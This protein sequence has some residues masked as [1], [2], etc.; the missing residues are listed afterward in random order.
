MTTSKKHY[1]SLFALLLVLILL[2]S[3]KAQT[4]DTTETDAS[5]LSDSAL[6]SAAT[7][8]A[9]EAAVILP[10]G[11]VLAGPNVDTVCTVTYPASNSQ[12]QAA[13]EAMV[14]Y[15]NAIVPEA[16]LTAVADSEQI[17]TEYR[18]AICAPD[19][20][21]S[22]NYAVALDDKQITLRGSTAAN[23]LDAVNYFKTV[24]FTD[25]YFVIDKALNFT[26][27]AGPEVLSQYPEKYYYYEDIY[28][29]SLAYAF[30]A[31][32]VD[33]AKSRLIVSGEDL[34]DKAVW[35]QGLVT[36][37]DYTVAV[38]DHTVL[39]SLA[40]AGGDVEVYETT[41]SCGDG[42]VMNLYCGEVHAHTSDSDGDQTVKQAYEYA[43]DVAKLDFFAVTDHSNSFSNTIYQNSHLP[44]ADAFNEP[45]TFAALYGYEQ[46]YNIKTGYYGHLNTINR[47]SLTTNSLPLAQFYTQMAKDEDAVVMFNHPG[48]TWGN[49]MEYAYYSPEIDAVLNLTEIK[50]T[51][52]ANYEYALSLTKG[53]HVS[54]VYNEDN[55]DPNWGNAKDACG[56]VL[57]PALTRQNVIDAFNKNRTYTTTD[58]TLKIYYKINDEWMGSRLNNPDNL[59]FSIQLSTENG[60]GLGTVSIIAE[61]GII[62]ATKTVGAKKE[63]TWEF[64]LAPHYDY[65]YIKVESGSNWCYTAPIWIENREQIT[66]G[67]LYQELVINTSGS[68]DHR[69]YADVTNNSGEVMTGVTVDFYLSA[70]SGFNQTKVKPAATVSVGDIAPGAT[71]T[72][73]AD[74]KYSASTP[75][76]YADVKATQNGKNYGAVSYM[77]I[78][79]LYFTEILP[80]TS[81]GGAADSYEYIELYN[82]SDAVIDLARYSMRY[83]SKAGAKAADLEANTWK[84]SG[85]IQP[86]ST[87]VIWMV[88]DT[89]KLTVTDFNKHFGTSLVEGKNIIKLTGAN[90]PHDKPVQLELLYG[91]PIVAR[92][93]YNW[94]TGVDVLANRAITFEYPTDYTMTAKVAKARLDPTP[95]K[96][97][98]GQVPKTVNP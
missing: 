71:V 88:S 67:E 75:R 90:I 82:N 18:I 79:T 48:Y 60:N 31:A 69:I 24:C 6:T 32:K 20:A 27:G 2:V 36:L 23:V 56:Y 91:S 53:W 85:K 62:V 37:T 57:A 30:D 78:S 42:S 65:Y 44:N 38:G 92:C 34:T 11:L 14:A 4:P 76:V 72:V 8:E 68:N 54:P 1:S 87:M 95:G 16:G 81:G 83:Y 51:S 84:L 29:P 96:L 10:D 17:G 55:H 40:N 49:F 35:G 13:A 74:L 59:H 98:E 97:T 3:C 86:H 41:F 22:S 28:T 7:T 21:L 52:A 25:G 80:L 39:L 5:V 61:D 19:S 63:F 12:L 33:T 70:T 43:R 94:G 47:A 26:S 77:E 93:W 73:H 50:S 89:N 45:G 66:V 46:T 15:I 9:T 58:K 64:D